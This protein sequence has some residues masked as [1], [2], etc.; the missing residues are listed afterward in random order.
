MGSWVDI[1]D[2]TLI[3]FLPTLWFPPPW[4]FFIFFN[5][6]IYIYIYIFL[7]LPFTYM[8]PLFIEKNYWNINL[9]PLIGVMLTI[10]RLSKYAFPQPLHH[11]QD[12]T[13][14]I[15]F[16]KITPYDIK[17]CFFFVQFKAF[18]VVDISNILPHQ[19]NNNYTIDVT[20]SHVPI[21]F[22]SISLSLL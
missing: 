13:R 20:V 11:R 17:H 15:Y 5:I 18:W 6:Y 8:I 3:L 7:H 19:L 16:F 1:I 9:A 4:T 14:S 21:F 10:Y 2:P 22:S 12:V